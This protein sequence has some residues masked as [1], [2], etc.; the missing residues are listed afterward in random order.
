MYLLFSGTENVPGINFENFSLRGLAGG[1]GGG[2]GL[3]KLGV[4]LRGTIE[5]WDTFW[6]FF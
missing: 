6:D 2:G 5:F 3:Q 4:I 1:G